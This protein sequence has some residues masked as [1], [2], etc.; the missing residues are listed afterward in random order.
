MYKYLLAIV[1]FY[2]CNRSPVDSW[3]PLDLLPYGV[4]ITVLAPLPD[5]A[6]VKKSDLGSI[7]QDITIQNGEDY[8]IQIY[9]SQ[10]ETTDLAKIK[11]NQMADVKANRYYSR[12]VKEEESGFIYEMMID[13]NNINYGFRYVKI[14]GGMEYVFQPGMV[15][16][17]S[18]E[19]AQNMYKGVQ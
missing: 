6:K 18:L 15:G 11:A 16:L 2:S 13:S 10:A 12:I 17:F 9:A 5:S 14:Q 8:Y 1:F 3:K 4:P 19:Q 7:L